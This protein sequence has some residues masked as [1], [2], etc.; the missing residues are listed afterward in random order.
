V[1]VGTVIE[2]AGIRAGVSSIAVMA[3]LVALGTGWGARTVR[4]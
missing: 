3:V 4:L 1:V 2:L